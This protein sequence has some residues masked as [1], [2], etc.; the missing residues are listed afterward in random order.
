VRDVVRKDR[1]L[2]VRAVA[3]EANFDSEKCLTMLREP[4]CKN[5]SKTVV[6]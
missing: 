6:R 1:R 3:E 4:L 2:G 5:G